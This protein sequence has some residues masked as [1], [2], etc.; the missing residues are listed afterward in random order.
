MEALW[1]KSMR[2][3][4]EYDL[5][6]IGENLK[7]LR[8]KNGFSVDE[9][10]EYLHMG[11][12]QAIYKYERGAG[13]PPADTLLALMDLYHAD[14][15]DIVEKHIVGDLSKKEGTM[16]LGKVNYAILE[17]RASEI[18]RQTQ[19]LRLKKYMEMIQKCCGGC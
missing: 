17:W 4:P 16:E 19:V 18:N 2:H 14:Y 6:V 10:R 15:H 12:V 13:Y 7:R 9:V 5:K 3:R 11:T 1:E 8:K